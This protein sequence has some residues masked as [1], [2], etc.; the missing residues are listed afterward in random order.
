MNYI[1]RNNFKI[2]IKLGINTILTPIKTFLIVKDILEED[3]V[4]EEEQYALHGGDEL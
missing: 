1:K 4:V 2:I 3:V